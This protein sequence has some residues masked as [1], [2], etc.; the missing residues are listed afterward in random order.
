MSTIKYSIADKINP[1][2]AV[3]LRKWP[4]LQAGIAHEVGHAGKMGL[5][6]NYLRGQVI[7]LHVRPVDKR[8]V[9]HYTIGYH[10]SKNKQNIKVRSYPLNLYKPREVYATATGVVMQNVDSALR[11]YDQKILQKRLDDL[12]GVAKK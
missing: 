4:S 11:G 3:L 2:F 6:W 1:L 9:P 10:I 7:T 5:Y 8:G 12:Q